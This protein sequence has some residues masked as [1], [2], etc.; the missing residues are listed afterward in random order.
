MNRIKKIVEKHFNLKLDEQ[1]RRFEVVFA[2]GCYFKICRELTKNSFQKI[3]N[4]LGKNHAT[5]MHG[6]KTVND[7][8]ETDKDLK[9]Q[10][11]ELLN[12]FSEYNK[13]K[14]KMN[15]TQLVREYNKLLLLCGQKDAK[16]NEL[17]ETIYRLADL[18]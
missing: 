16:I 10:F 4:T 9:D 17:T 15:I 6:I 3:G 5:V 18:D 8:I 13:I 1:T 7:L 14:E 2:R 11:D 12:K